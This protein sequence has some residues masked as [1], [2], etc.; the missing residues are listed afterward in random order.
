VKVINEYS[1]PINEENE[2]LADKWNRKRN[3]GV[4][5]GKR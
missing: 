5:L 3:S 2:S 1:C 4:D